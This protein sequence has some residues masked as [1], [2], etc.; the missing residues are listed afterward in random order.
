MLGVLAFRNLPD[1]AVAD[2]RTALLRVPPE[3]QILFA[4]AAEDARLPAGTALERLAAIWILN[5]A[6]NLADDLAD[7]ECDYLEPAVAPGVAFLL[8]ALAL[9]PLSRARLS[10][11]A[12]EDCSIA[13]TR[14]ASGQSLEVRG[15]IRDA[16]QYL[17]VADLIAGDQ[18]I[19]YL[20]VLW[21]GTLLE[22]RAE[23]IGLRMGRIGILLT[24]LDSEDRRFFGLEQQE[25][26]LV[27]SSIR[28][29]LRDLEKH[30]TS[31][32]SARLFVDF[33]SER[34]TLRG[35]GG[36]SASEAPPSR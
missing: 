12:L 33:A 1:R 26:R 29:A 18:Y 35:L 27:L 6:V 23:N 3:S 19:A 11:R 14:A 10:S 7:G 9:L 13:L 15:W 16:E 17:R 24:D 32:S 25:R 8:Q 5:A 21:D 36:A 30:A 2:A 22:D 20:R 4:R 31:S 34:L 28:R